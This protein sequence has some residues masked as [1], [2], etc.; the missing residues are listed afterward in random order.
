MAT[1][2]ILGD[3]PFAPPPAKGAPPAE[4]PGQA[5][6]GDAAGQPA[7]KAASKSPAPKATAKA[8]SEA[9]PSP[10][11]AGPGKPTS[12]PAPPLTAAAPTPASSSDFTGRPILGSIPAPR[13]V[14]AGRPGDAAEVDYGP[15]IDPRSTPSSG[16]ITQRTAPTLA[17]TPERAPT[18]PGASRGPIALW[19]TLRN[20]SL[21]DTDA[22]VDEFGRS[23]G[24]SERASGLL[25]FLYKTYF[26]VESR[27]LGHL[28]DTGRA[29]IVSN[30]SGMIPY[31]SLMI[32]HAVA[33]EHSRRRQVRPLV[34]DFLFHFPYLG[35]LLNRLGGVRACPEN[36]ERLLDE[37][38]LVAVFPEGQKGISKL[39][40]DRYQLQRFG[41]GGFIKLALR[42]NA[43]IIP[44]AVVG[45]EEIHPTLG[46]L[47][48]PGKPFGLAYL[49]LTPTFPWL[50]AAGLIP[51]PSKW[52]IA[53]G[54]PMFINTEFGP[55]GAEDRVLVNR[56]S[57]QVRG[58][59]QALLDELLKGRK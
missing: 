11:P 14:R 28:P 40:R 33:T 7:S 43:P 47:R 57:E 1:K 4:G 19:R 23:A 2:N 34:E 37:E 24:L 20:L 17:Y 42:K 26:R 52:Y 50:G 54:E 30:H 45:A 39:F 32:L 55:E 12:E 51:L 46:R 59:I 22:G 31:D 15:S 6:P 56:L 5:E 18:D 44:T 35:T 16:P 8:A 13:R 29:L 48:L 36:A 3:D 21:H 38:Q 41:R 53:F 27:G 49:P 9:A 58:R 10:A 25:D